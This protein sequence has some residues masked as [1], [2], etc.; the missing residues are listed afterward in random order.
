MGIFTKEQLRE[1]I[2]EKNLVTADDVQDMLKEM[3][4]EMLQDML[5]AEL[6]TEIGYPK[7]G[8]NPGDFWFF[9]CPSLV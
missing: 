4:S 2:R 8:Q 6:D 1:L 5:E 7:N 9:G 3:F